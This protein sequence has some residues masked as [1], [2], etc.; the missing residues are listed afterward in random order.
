MTATA[1]VHGDSRSIAPKRQPPSALFRSHT[2]SPDAWGPFLCMPEGPLCVSGNAL[3]PLSAR[4]ALNASHRRTS[5]APPTPHPPNCL[6]VL[7]SVLTDRQKIREPNREWTLRCPSG[8]RAGACDRRRRRVGGSLV[9]P[10]CCSSSRGSFCFRAIFSSP[11]TG[12]FSGM[13]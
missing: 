13:V 11:P 5:L 8:R 2:H 3:D 10:H 6:P 4:E 9:P 7:F 1:C 12:R